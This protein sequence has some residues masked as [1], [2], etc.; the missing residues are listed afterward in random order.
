MQSQNDPIA[1]SGRPN[2]VRLPAIDRGIDSANPQTPRSTAKEWRSRS[3]SW[4]IANPPGEFLR[5]TFEEIPGAV[6]MKIA[7][8]EVST[9][10]E[11]SASDLAAR[12]G[13]E[14]AADG[15]EPRGRGRREM[16]RPARMIG[17]PFEDVGLFVS[18]VVVDDWRE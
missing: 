12:D 7:L 3:N 1:S 16:E 11:G 4:L 13:G 8:G 9:R 10:M 15:V 6:D 14:E 17:L 2:R 5:A 18:G